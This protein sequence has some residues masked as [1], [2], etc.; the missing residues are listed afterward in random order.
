VGERV[1]VVGSRRPSARAPDT[2]VISGH[3]VGRCMNDHST[4]CRTRG[5]GNCVR[6]GDYRREFWLYRPG[7][8]YVCE[9][10]G[11]KLILGRA[12]K[13]TIARVPVHKPKSGKVS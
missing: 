13:S 4:P 1:A 7:A 5:N 2:V 9:E 11:R 12:P 6:S 8:E 10:C 3:A